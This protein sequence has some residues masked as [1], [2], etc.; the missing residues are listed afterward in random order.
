MAAQGKSL[1]TNQIILGAV[2]LLAGFVIWQNITKTKDKDIGL[3]G[4]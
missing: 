3:G 2:V 1:T 4:A